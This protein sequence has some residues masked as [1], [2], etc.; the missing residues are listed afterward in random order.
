MNA[1]PAKRKLLG[2]LAVASAV[3]M[4]G[5]CA[6]IKAEE[7][8]Q[9]IILYGSSEVPPNQSSAKGN[10]T[11]NVRPDGSVTAT[12]SV[13]GMTATA[14]HIHVAAAGANG[15]VIVPFTK[16]SENSFVAPDNAKMTPEQYASYKAGNTYVNVHSAQFPAGEIRA[17]LAGK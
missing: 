9:Q 11:V 8:G 13:T 6:S 17:Q 2:I 15:P 3:A 10:G 14:A 7:T 5:S 12:V 1:Y 16:I 4:L